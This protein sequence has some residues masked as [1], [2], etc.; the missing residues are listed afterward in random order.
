MAKVA[1]TSPLGA[2]YAARLA[3]EAGIPSGVLNVVPGYGP[4]AGQALC[5][6]KKVRHIEAIKDLISVIISL[7]P[8]QNIVQIDHSQGEQVELYRGDYDG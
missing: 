6:N 8:P 7:T 5:R 4:T 2:L 3:A 1:E